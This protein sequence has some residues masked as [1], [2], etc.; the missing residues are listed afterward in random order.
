MRVC[1]KCGFSDNLLWRNCLYKRDLVYMHIDD[2]KIE[3]SA[4]FERVMNEKFVVD[5][6]FV[7]HKTR[8]YV[9]R[10]EPAEVGQPF[11]ENFEL[12]DVHSPNRRFSAYG[13]RRQKE[14]KEQT[15]LWEVKP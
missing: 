11:G 14:L 13:L 12:H 9:L 15:K 7:Y 8:V 1:P 3:Y 4:L 6:Q 10:K 5:G 2:F